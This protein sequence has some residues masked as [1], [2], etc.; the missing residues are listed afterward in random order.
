MRGLENLSF[1]L[2]FLKKEGIKLVN[3]DATVINN[4]NL[5]LILGLIWTIIL[6]YQIQVSEGNSA[7]QEVPILS[8]YISV[9]IPIIST[10]I[11]LSFSFQI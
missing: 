7:K 4:G 10:N 3:I 2:E 11:V 6:R 8:L 9:L 5:K 1:A